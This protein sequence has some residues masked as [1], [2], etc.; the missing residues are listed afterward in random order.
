[1]VEVSFSIVQVYV[2]FLHGP[3]RQILRLK[4]TTDLHLG[5]LHSFL[6]IFVAVLYA[7][8]ICFIQTKIFIF[9]FWE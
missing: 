5:H 7:V 1:M 4:Q 3:P 2:T 9:I 8:L 6:S